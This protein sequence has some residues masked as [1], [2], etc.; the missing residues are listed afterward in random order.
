MKEYEVTT[1]PPGTGNPKLYI[2]PKLF[3]FPP[4]IGRE[5]SSKSENHAIYFSILYHPNISI[6]V[7][8]IYKCFQRKSLW[9]I[10]VRVRIISVCAVKLKIGFRK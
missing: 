6:Q 3:P 9:R 4:A 8:K 10:R 1:K 2:M 5:S 7:K